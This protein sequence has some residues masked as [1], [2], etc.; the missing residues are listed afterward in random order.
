MV[1]NE[2]LV[3]QTAL[4]GALLSQTLLVLGTCFFC[5]GL[6]NH[7]ESYSLVIAKVTSQLLLV[8]LAS[9]IIP[10]AFK[11]FSD[12]KQMSASKACA[13]FSKPVSLA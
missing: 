13:N 3:A 8:S 2:P 7:T 11:I 6:Q 4:T 5:G 12:G 10:A 1:K 9:L